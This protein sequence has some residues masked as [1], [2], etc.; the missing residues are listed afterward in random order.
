M[1]YL[2]ALLKGEKN[3]PHTRDEEPQKP[4]KTSFCGF[5]GASTYIYGGK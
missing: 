5:R 1:K 4:R 3:P 2:D